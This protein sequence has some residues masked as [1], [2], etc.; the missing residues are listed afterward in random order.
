MTYLEIL[1]LILSGAGTLASI[2]GIFF[3]VY[4]RYNGRMTRAFIAEQDREMRDFMAELATRQNREMREFI[5]EQNRQMR[6]S[7]A[8][9]I[10]AQN[11]EMREF[12]AEVLRKFDERADARQ[13]EVMEALKG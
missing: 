9:L 7:T 5:A 8:E 10:V 2:L 6:D 12:T 3:A 4:A 1:G 11:R 13:R